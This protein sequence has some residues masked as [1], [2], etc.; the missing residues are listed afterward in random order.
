MAPILLLRKVLHTSELVWCRVHGID[1]RVC[2]CVCQG[3]A[4]SDRVPGLSVNSPKAPVY[5]PQMR[6]AGPLL[7][8][9]GT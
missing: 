2:V 7:L 4:S 9:N 3:L 1:E 6:S 8:T 5:Q